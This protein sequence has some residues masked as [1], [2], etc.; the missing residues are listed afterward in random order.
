MF[1]CNIDRKGRRQRILGGIVFLL[2]GAGLLAWGGESSGLLT[3]GWGSAAAGGFMLFE[4]LR[5]W[6]VLKA[7]GRRTPP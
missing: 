4:G 7:L 3:A 5:G 1:T 6:C 2:I